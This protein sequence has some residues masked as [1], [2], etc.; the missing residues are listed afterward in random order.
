MAGGTNN[1]Q[2][3]AQLC[4]AHDGDKDD[5]PKMCLAV[6]VVVA[7]A[8]WEGG[9]RD[10]YGRGSGNGGSRRGG[11]WVG[12]VMLCSIFFFNPIIFHIV[13]ATATEG[14]GNGAATVVSS[15][16]PFS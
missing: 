16:D 15:T 14:Q 6:V 9:E 8:V 5:M 7:M 11:R 12:R 4:P 3:K 1:Y 13:T 2:L 10:G